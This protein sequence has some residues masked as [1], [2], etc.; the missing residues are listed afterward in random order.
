LLQAFRSDCHA[1]RLKPETLVLKRVSWKIQFAACPATV[2]CLEIRPAARDIELGQ[3]VHHLSVIWNFAAQRSD[4][5]RSL[6]SFGPGSERGCCKDWLR[7][8][9]QEHFAAKLL[10]SLDAL[11]K[12]HGSP[13]V[14]PPVRC[15]QYGFGR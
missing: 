4:G 13:G 7:S 11:G 9:L 12:L 3:G 6:M 5:F 10:Q 8:D 1:V 15:I 2:E 14:P